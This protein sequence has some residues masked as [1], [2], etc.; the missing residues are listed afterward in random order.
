MSTAVLEKSQQY[1]KRPSLLLVFS[2][3][4]TVLPTPQ[5][6]SRIRNVESLLGKLFVGLFS[7]VQLC[8]DSLLLSQGILVRLVPSVLLADAEGLHSDGEEG[9]LLSSSLFS[10]AFLCSLL[11]AASPASSCTVSWWWAAGGEAMSPGFCFRGKVCARWGANSGNSVKSQFRSLKNL[12]MIYLI[13]VL[14]NRRKCIITT[15]LVC[16]Y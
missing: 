6:T 7:W 3:G 11:S 4:N 10:D 2:M 16:T 13:T 9:A 15:E 12:S 5:P 1:T 8:G 14:Y